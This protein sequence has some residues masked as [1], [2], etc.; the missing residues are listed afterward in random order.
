MTNRD[1]AKLNM[2]NAVAAFCTTNNAIVNTVPALQTAV[3]NLKAQIVVLTQAAQNEAAIIVGITQNKATLKKTLAQTAT[4]HAAALFAFANS[5]NDEVLKAKAKTSFSQLYGLKDEELTIIT[6][7]IS[8]ELTANQA[9]L[10]PYGITAALITAFNNLITQYNTAVPQPRNAASQKK[11]SGQQLKTI[12]KKID[13]LLKLEMDKLVIQFK[14]TNIN[15]FNGYKS[16]RVIL[17]APTQKTKL[18]GLITSSANNQPLKDV[19]IQVL[20]TSY[21]D[22]TKPTGRYEIKIPVTGTY[23]VSFSK[24]GFAPITNNN[25]SITL[26]QNTVLNIALIPLP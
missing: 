11:V 6:Q 5:Q 22:T 14:T 8:A 24:T 25:V 15:F 19:V 20:N 16:N 4:S 2:Y 17:N 1:E 26:G 23:S 13:D 12:F 21:T 10:V 7:N 3:T 18:S 9:G